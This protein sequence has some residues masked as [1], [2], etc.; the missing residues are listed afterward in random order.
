MVLNNLST[1][2]ITL[3][4]KE[5]INY[6]VTIVAILS[7]FFY[8]RNDIHNNKQRSEDNE[9][10]IKCNQKAIDD[11]TTKSIEL[12]HELSL[13]MVVLKTNLTNITEDVKDIKNNR[14]N[15]N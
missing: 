6:L 11:N 7:V 12:I 4:L 9:K 15:H 10:E 14:S 13:Q 2:K 5:I 8:L 1:T 3:S